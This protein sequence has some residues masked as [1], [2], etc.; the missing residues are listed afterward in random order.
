MSSA[1]T[2]TPSPGSA[3]S[4]QPGFATTTADTTLT[5]ALLV[6]RKRKWVLIG[7]ILLGVL[8]GVY[9]S[10]T[11]P[12][13]Y[14]ASGRIEVR[15]GTANEYRVAGGTSGPLDNKLESEVLIITSE[16]LYLNVA[17]EMNL[18]NNADFMGYTQKMP[19]M[20]I[21]EPVIRHIVVGRLSSAVQVQLIPRTYII[22]ITCV[23]GK[24]QL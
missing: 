12:I 7:C 16:S 23:T 3:N 21:N 4:P 5:E 13:L 20:D 19:L 9:Q 2:Q 22:N 11:Q 6:L 17:R 10:A 18:A 14:T 1:S 8:A 24:P 15:S